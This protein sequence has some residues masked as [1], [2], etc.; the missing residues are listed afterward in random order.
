MDSDFIVDSLPAWNITIYILE[1]LE[2][3]LLNQQLTLKT[4]NLG[5]MVSRIGSCY[6]RAT[7]YFSRPDFFFFSVFSFLFWLAGVYICGDNVSWLEEEQKES[8]LQNKYRELTS[9]NYSGY[10]SHL[11][12]CSCELCFS[13]KRKRCLQKKNQNHM[14]TFLGCLWRFRAERWIFSKVSKSFKFRK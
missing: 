1:Y 2:H 13:V 9:N 14:T 5:F 8:K 11:F 6:R 3:K 7:C 4:N 10:L 12:C